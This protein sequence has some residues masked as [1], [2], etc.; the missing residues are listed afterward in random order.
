MINFSFNIRNPWSNFFK[1]GYVCSNNLT[2]HKFWELQA[3]RTSDIVCFNLSF[4]VKQD[5]A[6]FNL[7]IGLFSFNIN[8]AIYDHRHWDD[9]TKNWVKY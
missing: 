9:K 6:G 5:H 4:T 3:M 8:L 7:E 2:K 1:V